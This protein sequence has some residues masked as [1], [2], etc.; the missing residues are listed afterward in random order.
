M[1]TV[2]GGPRVAQAVSLLCRRLPS[3]LIL[4]SGKEWDVEDNVPITEPLC[5]PPSQVLRPP[6]SVLP[7]EPLVLPGYPGYCTEYSDLERRL[8]MQRLGRNNGRYCGET[9]EIGSVLQRLEAV[10]SH[11]KWTI[12]HLELPGME[13]LLALSRTPSTVTK[14]VYVSAGIHGDEPAGPLAVCQLLEEDNWPSSV[15]IWI[16]PCLNP[17]GFRLNSRE[18]AQKADLNRDYWHLESD[19]VA[20]HV[21]WLEKQPTFDVTLCLHED[22]EAQGF[23]LYELNP[24]ETPSLAEPIINA[25]AEVCP[26]DRSSTIEGWPADNGVLR[27]PFRP[28]E[29]PGWP[30]AFYLVLN[31][32]RQSYTLETPS[33]YPLKTRVQAQVVALRQVLESLAR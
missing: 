6:P 27:P 19:E 26:I 7:F 25:V 28:E 32:C 5:L 3:L 8:D 30:E 15:G 23:Y 13:R 4:G 2:F 16:C 12:E 21:A 24:D 31:K 20:R 14:R 1:L 11:H 33:D 18:N 9:I 29:R 22:W 17:S 10:G